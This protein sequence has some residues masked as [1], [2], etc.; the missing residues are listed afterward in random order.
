MLA[1]LGACV[2][3]LSA[4]DPLMTPKCLLYPGADPFGWVLR[5]LLGRLSPCDIFL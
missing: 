4:E 1:E 5:S 3:I 2:G